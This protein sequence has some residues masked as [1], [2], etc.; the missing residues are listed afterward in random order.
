MRLGDRRVQDLG[1]RASR[2]HGVIDLTFPE[3]RQHWK[4]L[5]RIIYQIRNKTG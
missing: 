1:V 4:D 3:F 2:L 5:D